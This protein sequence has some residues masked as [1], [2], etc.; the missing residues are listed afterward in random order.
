MSASDLVRWGALAAIVGGVL[1]FVVGL[2]DL[3]L[4]GFGGP[5]SFSEAAGTASWF[6]IS[7]LSLLAT[8]LG[9]FALVGLHLYHSEAAGTL[10]FVGFLVAFLGTAL[11]VGT[12]WMNA[13][14]VPSLAVEAP[15]FL[16][17]EQVAGPVNPALVLSGIVLAVGWALFGWAAL[18]AGVYP[19]WLAV[20]LIVVALAQLIPVPVGLLVFAPV[21]AL[22]GLVAFSGRGRAA[23]A[24]Q[25]SRVW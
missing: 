1:L 9:L 4:L 13:F 5:E 22:L 19:R 18:R 24:E 14:A 8:V 12:N 17:V 20:A 10:G 21:L 25:P 7:V 3:F 6:F 11:V 15:E 23:A 2:S 16:D